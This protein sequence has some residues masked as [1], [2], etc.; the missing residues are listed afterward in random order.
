[1]KLS[2][3]M[4]LMIAKS[5]ADN[6]WLPLWIHAADTAGVMNE[7][8]HKRYASLSELSGCLLSLE[9]KGLIKETERGYYARKE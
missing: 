5:G 9:M 7:L 8:I 4:R 6:K 2:R 1:M 3:E